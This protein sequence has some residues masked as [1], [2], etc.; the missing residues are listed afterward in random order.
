[1][2][3]QDHRG[4]RGAAVTAAVWAGLSAVALLVLLGPVARS[5]GV[6]VSPLL[7]TTVVALAVAQ[8]LLLVLRHDRPVATLVAVS[9]LQAGVLAV[10][11]ADTSVQGA[12][13][14]VAA[15]TAGTLLPA[16]RLVAAVGASVAVQAAG[17]AVATA[18]P[19]QLL[20]GAAG[21]AT[22]TAAAT[23]VGAWVAL[24]RAH[25][26]S[27]LAVAAAA[28]E[29]ESAMARS[30]V[31]EER[32]RM[33]RELHDVAAHHL[34]GLVVQ[35][36]AAE[37]LVDADPERAKQAIRDLREQGRATLR[38]MRSIVGVLRA[39]G[40]DAPASGEP[41]ADGAP[42]PGL[43]DLPSLV[44]SARAAGDRLEAR[45]SGPQVVLPPLADVA[46][47]RTAQEAL[48]NARRHAP[49]ARVVLAVTTAGERVLL[50]V[51]NEVADPVP[52]DAGFGLT[53]MRERAELVRGRL[54]VGP[55]GRG[56][57][58]VAFEVDG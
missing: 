40:G 37:R 28:V 4:R 26:R 9:V 44:E 41:Q 21:A 23:A 15:Y 46:V 51:E 55:T 25:Q 1:M 56:T 52:A 12:G 14:L 54:E 10:V 29:R 2:T 39:T 13:L 48:A 3:R 27:E 30:A 11:P 32:T 38:D 58:R 35:A 57:W 43:A 34:S 53:G 45:W 8:C 42:V 17:L 18:G 6:A 33:A 47:Y 50:E 24:R 49:G 19:G 16:R 31:A 5:E 36:S 7:L 20:L 22:T